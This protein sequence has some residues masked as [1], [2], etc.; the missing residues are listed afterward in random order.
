MRLTVGVVVEERQFVDVGV[1][2]IET[3]DVAVTVTLIDIDVELD[4]ERSGD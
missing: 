3:N 2:V 1:E 4:N